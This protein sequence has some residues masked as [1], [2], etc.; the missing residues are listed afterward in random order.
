MT[1]GALADSD[2]AR[3]LLAGPADR[4]PFAEESDDDDDIAEARLAGAPGMAG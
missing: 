3:R 1:E 4:V 2:W